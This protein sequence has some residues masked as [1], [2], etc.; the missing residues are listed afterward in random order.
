MQPRAIQCQ[1]ARRMLESA[2]DAGHIISFNRADMTR[3][4]G[5]IAC[6][7]DTLVQLTTVLRDPGDTSADPSVVALHGAIS[8]NVRAVLAYLRLRATY[9]ME[10]V[11][12]GHTQLTAEL[13]DLLDPQEAELFARLV[14]LRSDLSS[15]LR[16]S[17]ASG[18]SPCESLFVEIRVGDED[19][20]ELATM[21]GIVNLEPHSTHFVRREDV[22]QMIAAGKVRVVGE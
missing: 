11:D 19:L 21:E 6:L 12:T 5:D 2:R 14:D 20:G 16:V 13:H 15:R 10:M 1:H 9:L 4:Q 18:A 17:L 8:M 7:Y 22:R 3:A